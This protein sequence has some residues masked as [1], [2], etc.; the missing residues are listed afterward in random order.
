MTLNELVNEAKDIIGNA[1]LNM[2]RQ[3]LRDLDFTLHRHKLSM[4]HAIK[5]SE[6]EREFVEHQAIKLAIKRIKLLIEAFKEENKPD[7]PLR[8][9]E[10]LQ[11]NQQI[12]VAPHQAPP[13]QERVN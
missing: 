8:T 12:R 4:I 13:S 9:V 11:R 2:R 3:G 5:L 10:H 6:E 1:P 7:Y